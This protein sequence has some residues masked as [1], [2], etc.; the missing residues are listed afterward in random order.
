MRVVLFWAFAALALPAWAEERV[1]NFT[2][3]PLNQ[4]PPG[5]RSALVGAGKPGEW[6]VI[7]DPAGPAESA[8]APT[9]RAVLAQL[10]TERVD[11]HFPLL[12]F[13]GET[14]GDFKF[15]TRFKIVSGQ[16]G[17]MAGV[18]FRYQD[19]KN[20][21]VLLVSTLDGRFW[22][23][24]VANG[25]RGPLIG[26]KVTISRDE[27]HELGVECMG[28]QIRCFL[29]GTNLIPTMGD[30]S[31]SRG[32]VG[33]LTKSDTIGHFTDAKVVYTPRDILA[34]T[35][36]RSALKEYPR[37]VDLQ[38]FAA[39]P[40]SKELLVI[41]AKDEKTMGQPGGTTEQ[42]VVGQD[43]PYH[44]RTKTTAIVT[45]PLHDRNGEPIAAVRI[46]LKTFAGQTEENAVVRAQTVLRHIQARV[47]S[48][49]ELLQ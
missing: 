36:V 9:N 4:T 1:F 7:P 12:I 49:E 48:L 42:A 25:A 31:F 5:F 23:F 8:V 3:F 29:D 37:V 6:K 32:R 17:Q 40:G 44:A 30:N 27:W 28:N 21:Y 19:E 24:K 13:D 47:R 35:L 20:H 22:F 45:L 15:T 11:D 38:L 46:E 41:A 16:V 18:V 14:Y 34:Q 33:F 39:R 2:E 43:V 26:P 10:A